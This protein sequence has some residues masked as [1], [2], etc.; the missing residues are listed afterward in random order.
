MS[1]KFKNELAQTYFDVY[2]AMEHPRH[3]VGYLEDCRVMDDLTELYGNKELKAIFKEKKDLLMDDAEYVEYFL[4]EKRKKEKVSKD[5]FWWWID[6][7]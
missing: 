6:T 3:S 4:K 7:L 1:T 2:Q 5:R